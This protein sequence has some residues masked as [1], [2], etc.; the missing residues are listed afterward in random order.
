MT[1]F[2]E[3]SEPMP[4]SVGGAPAQFSVQQTTG[5]PTTSV[6]TRQPPGE[7]KDYTVLAIM[8][9]LFCCLPLGIVGIFKANEVRKRSAIGDTQGAYDA[10]RQAFGWS[11]AGAVCGAVL[12]VI[13]IIVYSTAL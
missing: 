5:A 11:I 10:S 3:K 7:I 8:V 2:N 1:T 12:T 4:G 9:T 6:I 13:L